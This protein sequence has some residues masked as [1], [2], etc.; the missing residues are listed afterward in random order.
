MIPLLLQLLGPALGPAAAA[1]AQHWND[2]YVKIG[3]MQVL[4]SSSD[5][6]GVRALQSEQPPAQA[7][8]DPRL[9]Q[10]AFQ[11]LLGGEFGI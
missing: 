5:A 1:A 3:D 10:L 8:D 11:G 7:I 4:S 2:P 6:W 9:R